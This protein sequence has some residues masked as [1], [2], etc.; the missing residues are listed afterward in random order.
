MVFKRWL[1]AASALVLLALP[2]V[3]FA[4]PPAGPDQRGAPPARGGPAGPQGQAGPRGQGAPQARGGPAGPQSQAGPRGQAA[5][6]RQA[7]PRGQAGPQTQASPRAQAGPQ[8]QASPRGQNG[9]ARANV[10]I[11]SYQRNVSAQRQF[12]AGTYRAPQGYSYHR[13]SYGQ[14]LPAIYFSRNF[15]LTNYNSYGLIA[16]PYGYVW[17]RYGPDAL[18]INE[19]TGRIVQ[20]DYGVFY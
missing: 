2:T 8:G 5:P 19:Y 18:L 10:N 1:F 11:T 16:P 12:H 13:W 20:V 3:G 17:V 7:G 6:Q 9:S 14:S 4:Q 15:W